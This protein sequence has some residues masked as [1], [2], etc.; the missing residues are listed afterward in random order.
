[1]TQTVA[2]TFRSDPRVGAARRQLLDVLAEHQAKLV[3]VRPAQTSLRSSYEQAIERFGG[4]RGG[5]LFFPYLGSG[6]GRGP[7]VELEDGS[8]KYDF[9]G[10]IGVH[11]FGHGHL[12]L[13]A[14]ALDAA[15]QNTVMQGNLQQNRASARLVQTL[16][17]IA[18]RGGADLGH[19]FLTSS[20][21][22][23]NENALKLAFHKM[24]PA[25]RVLAF[26]GAFSGRTLALARIT[27]KPAYR[28][29]LPRT[30][31]V[32]YV[33]FF[34]P[35][36][37]QQS[38]E[39]AVAT[40]K[41][42][43]ERF[44]KRHAVMIMEMVLGEAGFYPG[45]RDFFLALMRVLKEA[46]VPILVDEIQTFGR[47]GAPFAFQHFGLDEYVDLVTV[48]KLTQVCATLFAPAFKPAP[49]L[50]S[51]TFTAATSA[52]FA[53]QTILERLEGGDFFGPDGRVARLCG[54]MRD[55]LEAIGRRHPRRVR[56]PYG[57][58]AM[59][60]FTAFDGQPQT[61]KTLLHAL[62]EA[63]VIAFVA[64][65]DPVRMR[66]LVPVGCV[67]EDDIDTVCDLLGKTLDRVAAEL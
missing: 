65:A 35:K 8:V 42:H 58:G 33:P 62:F 21:A 23:A 24:A 40:L 59:V 60:A 14:A 22:M 32:D 39:K 66:F 36:R 47:T 27:D 38:T 53:A 16:I 29:G 41:R 45:D 49:G 20:G 18:C 6:M 2:H 61:A 64:G 12:E 31:A 11:Y 44:G 37:A 4:H 56:G 55:R 9:I 25:Q 13:T 54:R 5:A 46:G 30:V 63:G 26:R 28:V 10:G 67:T 1:M 7:L 34:N 57:L 51:Q 48:G 52:V 43:L 17:D 3:G 50:I 19:C 15:L